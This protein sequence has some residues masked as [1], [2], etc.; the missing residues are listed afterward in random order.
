MLSRVICRKC[1]DK[2]WPHGADL[3]S[4]MMWHQGLPK[5]WWCPIFYGKVTDE[6]IPPPKCPYKLEHGVAECLSAK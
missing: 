1:R 2:E 4:A 3:A 5:V 6:Y